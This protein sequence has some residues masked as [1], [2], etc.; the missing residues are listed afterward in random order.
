MALSLFTEK[1]FSQ[2]SMNDIVRASGMSKGGVYWHFPSKDSLV[3]AI[4]EQFFA[5]QI[6]AF[7]ELVR[8]QNLS[9]TERFLLLA[10]QGGAEMAAMA[11]QFPSPLEYYAL[12]MNNQD[13][14][15]TLLHFL[16]GYR[17]LVE[18]LVIQGIGGGEW[19]S[20]DGRASA[21]TLIAL[22]EGVL[23]IWSMAP[24]SFRLDEQLVASVNLLLDG[25]KRHEKKDQE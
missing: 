21:N 10:E 24:D 15:E 13:L 14:Q 5:A 18:Q 2:T 6:D 20:V 19:R 23:L 17:D 16:N 12:A 8:Q 4:F 25:L 3:R 9:A 22:I 11:A 7:T 1:G